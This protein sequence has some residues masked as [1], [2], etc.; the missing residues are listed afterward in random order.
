MN[1]TRVSKFTG[2]KRTLDLCITADQVA[3]YEAGALVQDAFPSL[4]TADRE[5]FITGVTQ[6]EWDDVFGGEE[7]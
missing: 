6:E 2:V 4:P 1:V 5:F 7:R 3:K